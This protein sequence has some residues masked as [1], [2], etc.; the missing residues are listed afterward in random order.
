MR[1]V[2]A[3]FTPHAELDEQQRQEWIVEMNGH[4]EIIENV[5]K[6]IKQMRINEESLKQ[7]EQLILA[8]KQHLTGK[9]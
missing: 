8:A 6:K 7:F 9:G 3:F 1:Y 4:I 2:D 5:Q